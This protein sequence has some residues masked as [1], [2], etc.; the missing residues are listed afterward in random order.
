MLG[1]R[2]ARNAQ[3]RGGGLAARLPP[4]HALAWLGCGR[5]VD[6]VLEPVDPGN[7]SE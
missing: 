4:A 6:E 3:D 1:E 2:F 5:E 7:L